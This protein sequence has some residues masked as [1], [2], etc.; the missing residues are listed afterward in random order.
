MYTGMDLESFEVE[1]EILEPTINLNRGLPRD[2]N[3]FNKLRGN[4]CIFARHIM[5]Q[6]VV[7]NYKLL[8]DKALTVTQYVW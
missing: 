7:L 8:R 5:N 6:S 1:L 3:V 4:S 2:S